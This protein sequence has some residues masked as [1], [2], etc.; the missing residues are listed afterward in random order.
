MVRM[1]A[2]ASSHGSELSWKQIPSPGDH[3]SRRG[4]VCDFVRDPEPEPLSQA[5]PAFLTHRGCVITDIC[6]F[7]L[8]SFGAI[9]YLAVNN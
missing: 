7:K 3:G 4:L 9:C 1:E 8:L 2:S 6:H 5:A